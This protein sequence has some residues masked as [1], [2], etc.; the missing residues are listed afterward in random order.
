MQK[1]AVVRRR[2]K[3]DQVRD[4]AVNVAQ[5]LYVFSKDSGSYITFRD[6]YDDSEKRVTPVGMDSPD[7]VHEVI[8]RLNKPYW[9]EI[10]L[11]SVGL[12]VALAGVVIAIALS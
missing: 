5:V 3:D 6:E 1:L 11:R 7:P 2:E 9:W 10:G 4:A 8:R 12:A